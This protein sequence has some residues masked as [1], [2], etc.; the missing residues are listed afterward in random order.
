MD[1]AGWDQR[2]AASALVWSAAPNRWLVAELAQ[3]DPPEPRARALD[4]AA[5]EGRNAL[6][7][8]RRGWHVVASDFSQVALDKGQALSGHEPAEVQARL[9]W[10]HEDLVDWVPDPGEAHLV[11][12]AY[13]HL[14]A[15]DRQAVLHRAADALAPGG[16]LLVIGHARDNIA[17]GTGGPQDPSVLYSPADLTADLADRPDLVVEVADTR[18]RPVEGADRPALDVVW[19]ARRA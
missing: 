7:L 8:A 2:Y 13:L 12:L 15:D 18:K 17:L 1:S 3:L 4:L 5:G 6:E 9:T 19:R 16:S 14:R 10:R 11:L